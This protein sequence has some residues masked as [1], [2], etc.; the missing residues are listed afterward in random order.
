MNFDKALPSGSAFLRIVFVMGFKT[1]LFALS[2]ELPRTN[3]LNYPPASAEETLAQLDKIWPG[4]F[5]FDSEETIEDGHNWYFHAVA[6][7]PTLLF[8]TDDVYDLIEDPAL[9]NDP[10]ES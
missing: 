9:A 7:G 2:G 6:F 4:K 5:A 1:N 10:R 8:G 3:I